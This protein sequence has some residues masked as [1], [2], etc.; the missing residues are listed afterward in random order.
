MSQLQ[1]DSV[2]PVGFV[3]KERSVSPLSTLSQPGITHVLLSQEDMDRII[4]NVLG[5]TQTFADGLTLLDKQFLIRSSV[6]NGVISST[7]LLPTA[8]QTAAD[9]SNEVHP[10]GTVWIA[11][12]SGNTFQTDGNGSWRQVN[13]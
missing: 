1:N 9:P 12:V 3:D 11:S 5:K 10:Y 8:V 6:L 7:D 2:A 4:V 13:V